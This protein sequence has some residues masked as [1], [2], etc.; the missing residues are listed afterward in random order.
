MRQMPNSTIPV[1]QGQ[2]GEGAAEGSGT[3]PMTPK[4]KKG[5]VKD[6]EVAIMAE[7]DAMDATGNLICPGCKG[8]AI[9]FRVIRSKNMVEACESCERYL[10]VGCLMKGLTTGQG[11]K[12]AMAKH[13][14]TCAHIQGRGKEEWLATKQSFMRKVG[15]TL[16][17]GASEEDKKR[18]MAA[19][20]RL[21]SALVL[22]L[23]QSQL[24]QTALRRSKRVVGGEG[25]KRERGWRRRIQREDGMG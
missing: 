21:D 13:I 14:K 4:V 7:L 1:A 16:E 12:S 6:M 2:E 3:M 8:R 24:N 25:I 23:G 11:T 9:A 22:N 17:A 15:E 10:C 20:G 18:R 5:I 19:F